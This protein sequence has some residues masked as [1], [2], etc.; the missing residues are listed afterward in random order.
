MSATEILD[1]ECEQIAAAEAV[2]RRNESY[3]NFRVPTAAEIANDRS[4]V[5]GTFAYPDR[6]EY[7]EDGGDYADDCATAEANVR[8]A[9][10]LA[11][12][13]SG[14]DMT[15]AEIRL[16]EHAIGEIRVYW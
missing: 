12:S 13:D 10:I 4:T 11:L 1:A 8:E 16:S 3:L 7:G 6:S 5:V 15:D 2:M 14:I 9:V